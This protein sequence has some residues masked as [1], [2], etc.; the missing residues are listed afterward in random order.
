MT[1]PS[2]A[3]TKGGVFRADTKQDPFIRALGAGLVRALSWS[4]WSHYSS[5]LGWLFGT[6]YPQV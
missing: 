3:L 2:M 6:K 1:V 4:L 5:T